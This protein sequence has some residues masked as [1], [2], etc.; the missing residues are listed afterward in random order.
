MGGLG[1]GR[2]L[3]LSGKVPMMQ[4]NYFRYTRLKMPKN[5]GL[6]ERVLFDTG[7]YIIWKIQPI[8]HYLKSD[9]RRRTAVL[10][11]LNLCRWNGASFQYCSSAYHRQRHFRKAWSQVMLSK[12]QGKD[13]ENH[14]I[15]MLK[16][17]WFLLTDCLI[18]L[19]TIKQDVLIRSGY[20]TGSSVDCRRPLCRAVST[21]KN[22]KINYK[23]RRSNHQR[24]WN[25]P[26]WDDERTTFSLSSWYEKTSL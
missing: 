19:K 17:D 7:G 11:S 6:F 25:L 8:C 24:L 23:N 13:I 14:W 16:A 12:L 21:K 15:P 18:F 2:Y 5:F 10:E 9:M 4:P 1:N 20:L 3:P 22:W 26:L